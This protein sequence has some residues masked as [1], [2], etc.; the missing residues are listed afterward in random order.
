MSFGSFFVK[1]RNLTIMVS[2]FLIAGILFNIYYQYSYEKDYLSEFTE[3]GEAL[4]KLETG[5]DLAVLDTEDSSLYRY[6]QMGTHTY[7]NSSMQMGTNSASYY[8]S[9]AIGNISN[10]LMKC[11]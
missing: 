1:K 3:Q 5:T 4:D 9:V 6:D 7:E 8:F 11:I 10:F 2:V